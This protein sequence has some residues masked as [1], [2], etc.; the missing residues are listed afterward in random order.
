[1]LKAKV[2]KTQMLKPNE[3]SI[4]DKEKKHYRMTPLT[5]S[6]FAFKI[7]PLPEAYFTRMGEEL[8]K[9]A[10]I[11]DDALSIERFLNFH[12]IPHHDFYT[13]YLKRS[14][15]LARD[16]QFALSMIGERREQLALE[17]KHNANVS[18][19][20]LPFFIQRFKKTAEWKASLA[21][22]ED[23]NITE[24]KVIVIEKFPEL[25]PEKTVD[26][27]PEDKEPTV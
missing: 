17:N 7:R 13:V 10:E 5:P 16:Y 24:Q 20:T 25:K 22:K 27:M 11:D 9:W 2:S 19:A 12:K 1:M 15:D 21:S 14:E 18:L 4:F 3:P 26:P 8:L 6:D 23:P